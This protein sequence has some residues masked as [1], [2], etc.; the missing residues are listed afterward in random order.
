MKRVVGLILSMALAGFLLKGGL[1]FADKE[2]LGSGNEETLS[3]RIVVPRDGWEVDKSKLFVLAV[4]RDPQ[5][6][7]PLPPFKARVKEVRFQYRP[8]R[9]K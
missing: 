2:K 4:V 5:N 1:A 9:K 6:W 3:A 7:W 8:T